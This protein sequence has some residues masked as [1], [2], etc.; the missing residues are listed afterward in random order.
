[1]AEIDINL[2][3]KTQKHVKKRDDLDWIKKN[4]GER[5][6]KRCRA[7]EMFARILEQKG[8]LSHILEEHFQPT[9]NLYDDLTQQNAWERFKSYVYEFYDVETEHKQKNDINIRSATDLMSEAGYILYPECKTE[10]DIQSFRHYYYRGDD[11][12]VVYDGGI[13]ERFKG[14][15]LCTFNGGR[16]NTNRVW[17]AVKK[18]VDKIKRNDFLVPTRQDDYGTSVISIQFSMGENQMLSIKNRYNHTVNNPDNTFN[19]NLDYIIPGLTDAFERDYGVKNK[20]EKYSNFEL[21]GYVNVGGKLYKYNHEI[22]NVYYCE[23]NIIIDNFE[24]KQLPSHVILTDYFIFDPKEKKVK[25]YDE[26][27][28]DSFPKSFGEIERIDYNKKEGKITVKV[29]DGNDVV[30]LVDS[31]MRIVSLTNENI[32]LCGGSFLLYNKTL[33]GLNLPNLEKCGGLFLYENRWLK[34][35]NLP[36]LKRCESGF[37]R[38]NGIL[39]EINLQNLE[40]CG[41]NFLESNRN[42]QV[43]IMP[44]LKECGND[45]LN[46]NDMMKELHLE[47]LR[48]CGRGFLTYN[49]T[50]EVVNLENLEESGSGFLFSNTVLK[51]ANLSNFRTCN[52]IENVLYLHN[53]REQFLENYY[54][55]QKTL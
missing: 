25:V 15:E 51:E 45:F 28:L 54:S 32:N 11:K 30:V 41:D 35:L 53:K 19:S 34:N 22:N 5:F 10:A 50:L 2:V 55:Q 14:E 40:F 6:A 18:D 52:D 9:K 36:N 38:K 3:V 20:N 26:S 24:V 39:E 7:G 1:M 33:Q 46:S 29:K 27:I 23:N 48:K 17:F 4:F 42:L 8:A 31:A 44:K 49:N 43:L 13:P 37:L 12:K 47:N 16:L 21:N